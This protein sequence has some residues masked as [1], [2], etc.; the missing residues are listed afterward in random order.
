MI[1]QSS[2]SNRALARRA[3]RAAVVVVVEA[4]AG[5]GPPNRLAGQAAAQQ[6]GATGGTAAAPNPAADGKA[7][8]AANSAGGSPQPDPEKA[9]PLLKPDEVGPRVDRL[10]GW[11]KQLETRLAELVK[12]RPGEKGISRTRMEMS[13]S[14]TYLEL[15]YWKVDGHTTQVVERPSQLIGWADDL[16]A[17][18]DEDVLSD[19]DKRVRRI[20]ELWRRRVSDRQIEQ[21]EIKLQAVGSG[22]T[23][24]GG[25]QPGK[26]PDKSPGDP[27]DPPKTPPP[28]TNRPPTGRTPP[29]TTPPARTVLHR[30]C[31]FQRLHFL[32]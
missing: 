5:L 3:I 13:L 15:A 10:Q 18:I 27:A 22:S 26:T 17:E 4:I 31:P 28:L 6:P 14:L 21:L 12:T 8:A 2:M 25:S 30:L 16:M 1:N 24:P 19:S 7:N 11:R 9:T 20:L 32:R 29:R 23:E